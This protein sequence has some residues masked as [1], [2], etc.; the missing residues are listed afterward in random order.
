M[1]S[2]RCLPICPSS[3]SG[4]EGIRWGGGDDRG[5]ARDREGGMGWDEEIWMS[6]EEG[7]LECGRSLYAGLDVWF[8]ATELTWILPPAAFSGVD[9]SCHGR[10]P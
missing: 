10:L 9:V 2:E 6:V 7:G 3:P 1:R 5:V 4:V 8:C